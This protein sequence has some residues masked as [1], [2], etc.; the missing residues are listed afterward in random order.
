M[1]AKQGVRGMKHQSKQQPIEM[2]QP[3][4]PGQRRATTDG[5]PIVW[6]GGE[7][8]GVYATVRYLSNIA[9][10]IYTM[11]D[12]RFFSVTQVSDTH[13]PAQSGAPDTQETSTHS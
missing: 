7:G 4:Q 2:G 11:T 3:A 12:N 6:V 5:I 13:L 10:T 8:V 1:A 9:G